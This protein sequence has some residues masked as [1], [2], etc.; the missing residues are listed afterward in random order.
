MIG[1]YFFCVGSEVSLSV[2][3]PAFA[4]KSN[5]S[6]T[7]T[8]GSQISATFWAGFAS[9]RFISIFLAIV[10][11]PMY[12]MLGNFLFLFIAAILLTVGGD[13]SVTMLWIG[14]GLFGA[15]QG[16]MFATGILWFESHMKVT[17]A[18]GKYLFQLYY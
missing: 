17:N 5:L 13:Q 6:L 4:V 7:K 1:F 11:K 16:S 2:Y 3:V 8:V 12:I 18:I 15:G 14:T 9:M 10:L